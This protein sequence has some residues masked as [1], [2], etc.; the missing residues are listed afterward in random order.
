V[1]DL[2]LTLAMAREVGNSLLTDSL[3][4]ESNRHLNQ[5]Y[6]LLESMDDG[7]MA[8]NEQGILQF[9]NPQAARLLHL[10]AQAC[11]GKNINDLV[12]LPAL[13]RRATK[14]ARSS[15]TPKSR[16]KASTSLSMRSSR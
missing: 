15:A 10:D 11:Q 7:V 12:T 4:A 6:G 14:Q 2:S 9:L 16:S 8:W 1:A 13:L 5:M 3:L